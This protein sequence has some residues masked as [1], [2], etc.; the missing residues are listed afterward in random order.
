MKEFYQNHKG[1]V[2]ALGFT[3]LTVGTFFLIWATAGS[4]LP[5]IAGLGAK[6]GLNLG[7]LSTWGLPAAS[8]AATAVVTGATFTAAV[9]TSIMASLVS[10]ACSFFKCCF[11]RNQ[12][13]DGSDADKGFNPGGGSDAIMRAKGVLPDGQVV[14]EDEAQKREAQQLAANPDKDKVATTTVVD[15][16]VDEDV[17]SSALAV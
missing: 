12:T 13:P 11:C 14:A 9:V 2:W 17:R 4:S 10:K 16:H 3:A 8:A 5:F 15:D 7:F 1:L 6:V